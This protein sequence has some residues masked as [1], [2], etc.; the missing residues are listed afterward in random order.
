MKFG[1][2]EAVFRAGGQAAAAAQTLSGGSLGC[3]EGGRRPGG[4]S[5]CGSA[6][7]AL[8]GQLSLI[9]EWRHCQLWNETGEKQ[10][11]KIHKEES[12]YIEK[13]KISL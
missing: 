3:P 7:G 1:E 6:T 5:H 8:S 9:C 13:V 10:R 11:I 2:A 12:H 4:G